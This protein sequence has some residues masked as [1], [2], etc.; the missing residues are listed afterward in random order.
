MALDLNRHPCFNHDARKTHARIHLPVAPL[1]NIQCKYCKRGFDCVHESRPG[2]SSSVLS[3][4]QALQYLDEAIARD[5]RISVVGIAGPGDPFANA[6]ATM[7]TLRGVRQKYPQMLL[8]VASNGLNFPP[9]ADEI[10]ALD[11][12]H[13]TITVNAVD[14][15]I[16]EQ[17]YAWV[18]DGRKTYRGRAAAELLLARQIESVTALKARGVTVKINAII[19]PGINEEHVVAVAEKMAALGADII[20][21]VPLYPVAD[22]EFA[23][24]PQPSKELVTDVREAAGKFLPIMAHCTRCRADAVGLL[25]EAM[26]LIATESLQRCASMPL[27]PEQER[28]Y[29]AVATREG[30]LVNMH[31][32]DAGQLAIFTQ[33]ESGFRLVENRVTPPAGGGPERWRALA[34]VLHD[35]RALLT[36]GAGGSPTSVLK[37]E[38]IRVVLM[39]GLIEEGL[40][41]V[42]RNAE[43]RAPL[44]AKFR[45]GSGCSG[46]GQG[47]S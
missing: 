9:Y 22:T 25:G 13:V 3:P 42:Y 47:C 31:L 14:P 10:A 4:G 38:G 2:V 26:P 30:M 15:A 45:C 23:D 5:P 1:C 29:V 34:D 41:A 28:P 24:I 16:G 32:G 27:K 36:S 12:S 44:R 17:I 20:N 35:C 18:R 33:D 11:V 43:V 21:C 37:D 8:C 7:E 46:N 40:D 39:E 6:E 19:I